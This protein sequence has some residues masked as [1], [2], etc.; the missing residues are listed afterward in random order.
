VS[1][2]RP[3]VFLDRD[4]TINVDT[5]YVSRPER[6]SLLP[7]AAAAIA[8]LNAAGIPVIVVSNQSGIGRGYFSQADYERVQRRVEELLAEQG[9][10][11]DGTYVCPHAP[12]GD[13]ECECRKPGALLYRK[14]SEEHALDLARSWYIGDRWRDIAVAAEL[15]GK[16]VLVPTD[17]TPVDEMFRAKDRFAVATTLR[18]A[19][20]RILGPEP[21]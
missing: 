4:G 20:D 2:L 8:R 7:D 15:G 3:A 12:D 10:H 16:G 14:A 9:A 11:I 21:D 1:A 17:R 19:V 13:T 5:S 18:A 6:V